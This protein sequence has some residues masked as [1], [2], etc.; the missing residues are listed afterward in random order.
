TKYIATAAAENRSSWFIFGSSREVYGEQK[1]FPVS[2]N[3]D[4]L[5]LNIYGFYKLEGERIVKAS[6]EKYCVLRFSN[7]YGNAYDIPKRV[8][9]KFVQTALQGGELTLEGGA[10]I[11]DFT[12]IDDTVKSI[13]RCME[14]LDAGKIKKETIH[15][16]PGRENRI[17][18]IIDILREKQM[19]FSVLKKDARSYDVQ[20]FL[21]NSNHMR[22]VL[23]LDPSNFVTLE[24]G[25]DKYLSRIDY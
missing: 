15:I 11:I 22:D 10:Q 2:E 24:E 4:L 17:T 9:P 5:P 21:G 12:F 7:V 19:Y 14:F 20:Q 8:I 13:I 1:N 16:L 3:A 6:F 18:D 23:E 25:I